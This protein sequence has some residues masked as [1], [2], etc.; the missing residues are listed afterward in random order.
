MRRYLVRSA[1]SALVPQA[2]W[3]ACRLRPDVGRL[4]RGIS[5]GSAEARDRGSL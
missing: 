1:R 5:G 4:S 2:G 3:G